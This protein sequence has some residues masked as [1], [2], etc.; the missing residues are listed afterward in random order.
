MFARNLL[1]RLNELL[2]SLMIICSCSSM[3]IS[4]ESFSISSLMLNVR[5]NPFLSLPNKCSATL[6][7]SINLPWILI[8]L[9]FLSSSN[10][11]HFCDMMNSSFAPFFQ[12][13]HYSNQLTM[14]DACLSLNNNASSYFANGKNNNHFI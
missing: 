7:T 13:F 4:V 10:V 5:I 1:C 3:E 6:E 11:R 12:Y 14:I 9:L 8:A 2:F